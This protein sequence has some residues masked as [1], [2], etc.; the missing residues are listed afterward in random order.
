MKI[1]Q[2]LRT[3]LTLSFV[4]L[5]SVAA[6]VAFYST[7]GVTKE[8]LKDQM[9]EQLISVAAVIASDI[10]GEKL[11]GIGKGSE[12]SKD[13]IEIRNKLKKAKQAYHDIK[14]V[15]AYKVEKGRVIFLVDGSYGED[16]DAALPGDVYNESTPE[17]VLGVKQKISDKDFA[18]D[19]WGTFLSGYA[20]VFDSKGNPVAAIGVDMLAQRVLER[21]NF[22]GNTIYIIITICVAV[23]GL[24]IMY[25]SATIIRDIKKLN[26]AAELVSTGKIDRDI[27][28]KRSDEIGELAESFQRMLTS[29]RIVRMYPEDK[30]GEK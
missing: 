11:L 12:K 5:I 22:I 17:M 6:L 8:V 10:S 16:S 27:E 24:I 23:A 1:M 28:I 18:Q 7:Y 4:I 29:L 14:Y 2:S 20:P 3:K 15:Y 13:F 9:K 30:K 25:F 21:Q 26:E 19:K